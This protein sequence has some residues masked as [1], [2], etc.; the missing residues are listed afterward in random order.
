MEKP[1]RR[2]PHPQVS[3]AAA[4]VLA[5]QQSYRLPGAA[6][7]PRT[8]HVRRPGPHRYLTACVEMIAL[9]AILAVGAYIAGGHLATF[10]VFVAFPIILTVDLLTIRR[11]G[12]DDNAQRIR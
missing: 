9:F 4:R 6:A 5:Y 2:A 10:V 8:H 7:S 3:A 1:D 11:D 12:A